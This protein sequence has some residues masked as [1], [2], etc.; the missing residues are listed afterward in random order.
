[1]VRLLNV[2]TISIFVALAGTLF[3]FDIASVSGVVGTD[4]YKKIYGNPLGT[5]QGGI[6]GAMAASSFVGALS[7][8]FLGEK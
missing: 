2:S 5:R 4:Q 8:S 7:S 1:M 3:G 6:T